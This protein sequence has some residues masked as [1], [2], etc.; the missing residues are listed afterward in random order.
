MHFL[1]PSIHQRG[2]ESSQN[3]LWVLRNYCFLQL[4]YLE[5]FAT[6]RHRDVNDESPN[7]QPRKDYLS[8]VKITGYGGKDACLQ[9]WR[10]SFKTL[11]IKCSRNGSLLYWN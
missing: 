8:S 4:Y 2:L 9:A 5:A 7:S 3:L 10:S 11:E 1:D 6:S